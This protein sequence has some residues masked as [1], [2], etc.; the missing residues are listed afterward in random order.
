MRKRLWLICASAIC[1]AL[2]SGCARGAAGVDAG[3]AREGNAVSEAQTVQIEASTPVEEGRSAAAGTQTAVL[4]DPEETVPADLTAADPA[5][6]PSRAEQVFEKG[7]TVFF[8][9][10]EQDGDE[11]NG[12]EPIEWLILDVED[13]SALLMSRYALDAVAFNDF[14]EPTSW[15][16]CTLRTWLNY[17]FYRGAFDESERERIAETVLEH[18]KAPGGREEEAV[19]DKVFLLSAEEIGK[20]LYGFNGVP[21]IEDEA[22]MCLPTAYAKSEGCRW[23][24]DPD[25]LAYGNGNWWLRTPGLNS[26]YIACVNEWGALNDYGFI[27]NTFDCG[28]RPVLRVA[29][30]S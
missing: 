25:S 14:S 19:S 2:L 15:S 20:L 26:Y 3:P 29:V 13:G 9:R 4:T 28:V 10:Y 30:G 7:A 12:A 16:A 6:S 24:D 11:D 17:D 27:A 5:D 21:E 8:G 1:L 23:N 22:R 18:E